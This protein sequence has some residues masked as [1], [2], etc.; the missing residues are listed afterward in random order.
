MAI[1]FTILGMFVSGFTQA[2]T[3]NYITATRELRKQLLLNSIILKRQSLLY[4]ICGL[5][6]QKTPIVLLK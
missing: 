5:E 2:G 4:E 1:D 3:N 6:I